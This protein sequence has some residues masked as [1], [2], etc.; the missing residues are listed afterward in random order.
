MNTENFLRVVIS[1][2]GAVISALAPTLPYV[3]LCTAVVGVDCVTACRLDRRVRKAYPHKT[4]K[5][6][7]KF[8]SSRF[9]DVVIT[10]MLVYA[11]LVFA[12]FLHIYVTEGLPFHA[13]K[14]A[15]G[16]VIGWQAWSILENESS[17]N[18]RRWAK[19]LQTVMVDK[20]ERHFDINLDMFK[21]R[22]SR[23]TRPTV[24]ANVSG[25]RKQSRKGG[26]K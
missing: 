19:A 16:A 26:A 3:L 18:G 24:G 12:Y 1:V 10:L 22:Q 15:A 6:G 4:K 20:T 21:G 14:V 5:Y 23:G 8:M 13:L 2:L 17:C 25:G 7:G 11:L 9:A